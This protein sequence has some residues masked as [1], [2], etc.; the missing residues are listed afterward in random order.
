M[1]MNRTR[2]G[3]L[4]LTFAPLA[5]TG[6]GSAASPSSPSPTAPSPISR[7]A[8]QPPSQ[9]LVVFTE[10]TSGFSTT[11]LRDVQEQIVQFNT[12]NELIWTADGTRLPGF[13][14]DKIHYPG[15]AFIDVVGP[16]RAICPTGCAFEVRFGTRDGE[17]RA[18]LTMDYV[19]DNP[20]TLVDVEVT[21]G[22]LLVTKTNVFAPGTFTLSGSVTELTVAGHR[23]VEAVSVY[24]LVAS[25]WRGATTDKNGFYQ[26]AGMYDGSNVVTAIKEGY[27]EQTRRDVSIKGDTRYD[28]QL[29]RR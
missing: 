1:H 4:L 8:P 26:M 3:L 27:E 25:G 22:A 16:S 17:R 18:Y 13:E 23:P 7:P 15:T 19:H 21:G 28:I 14:V 9:S 2:I 10:S 11:D 5:L 6:C 20:G 12:A 29:V 24:R